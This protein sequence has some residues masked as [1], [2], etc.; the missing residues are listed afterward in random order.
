MLAGNEMATMREASLAYDC[1]TCCKPVERDD[2][3]VTARE[4]ASAGDFLLHMH[5]DD[6]ARGTRRFHV[7]HFRRQ[8]GECVY[9]LVHEEGSDGADAPV[10]G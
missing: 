5:G 8:I 1:P 3:Y 10:F 6:S 2:D 7:A 9:E 4:Y